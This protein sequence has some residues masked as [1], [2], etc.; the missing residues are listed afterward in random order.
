MRLF[1]YLSN[2]TFI[3]YTYHTS[4]VL[5]IN[6]HRLYSHAQNN[7]FVL[8]AFKIP[9]QLSSEECHTI[10][11]TQTC[12]QRFSHSRSLSLS[13]AQS[14]SLVYGI[15]SRIEKFNMLRCIKF[16]LPCQSK[17]I[18]I[19]GMCYLN[20]PPFMDVHKAYSNCSFADTI[21]GK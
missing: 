8:V 3:L 5:L 13:L 18:F 10:L 6:F 20:L 16:V 4:Y 2:N 11:I 21:I 9:K 14:I 7:G 12:L 15:L 19:L 17:C 1:V